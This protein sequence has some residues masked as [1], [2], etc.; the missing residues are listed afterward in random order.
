MYTYNCYYIFKGNYLDII[1]I[2][3]EISFNKI[4]YNDIN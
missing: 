2:Y 3:K 1:M 4:I